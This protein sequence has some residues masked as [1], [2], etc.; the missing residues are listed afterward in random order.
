MMR[1]SGIFLMLVSFSS[2]VNMIECDGKNP[3]AGTEQGK[4]AAPTATPLAKERPEAMNG[5]VK[6]LAAGSNCTVFES[7]VFVARDPQTYQELESLN[8]TLPDQGA[9]RML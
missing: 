7:F 3:K 4:R 6:E 1:L 8:I 2:L 9:E 5:E